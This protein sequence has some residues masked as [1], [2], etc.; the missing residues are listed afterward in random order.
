MQKN[1]MSP[2]AKQILCIG[3]LVCAVSFFRGG[4]DVTQGDL[5]QY[6]REQYHIG[7]NWDCAKQVDDRIG[8]LL[9]YD[10]NTNTHRFLLYMKNMGLQGGYKLIQSDTSTYIQDGIEGYA[11]QEK[12]MVLFSMNAAQIKEMRVT[13]Q[14]G[15]TTIIPVDAWNPFA[16]VLPQNAKDVVLYNR[17]G[18][19]VPISNINVYEKQ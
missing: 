15:H 9:F 12:G 8:A 3:L 2:F 10:E 4:D 13:N 16:L 6:A 17:A 11:F 7:E 1:K 18:E 19:E 5:E 14:E